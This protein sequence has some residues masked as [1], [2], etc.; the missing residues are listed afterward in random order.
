[1]TS[2]GTVTSNPPTFSKEAHFD[3]SNFVT[4][5][6]RILIAAHMRGTQIYLDSSIVDPKTTKNGGRDPQIKASTGTI[7]TTEDAILWFS[8]HSV[9]F[10]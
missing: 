7:L 3:R 10:C 4:F 2:S 6:D 5:Q 9:R 1:M 8:M